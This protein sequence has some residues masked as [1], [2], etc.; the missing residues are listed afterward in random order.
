MARPR[1][2]FESKYKRY[3]VAVPFC[4]CHIW[5]GPITNHGYGRVTFGKHK[6]T[7]A[8]RASYQHFVGPLKDD[9]IIMHECDVPLCVNPLHLRKGTQAENIADKVAKKR[10]AAGEAHGMSKLSD[11]QVR[12]II[13]GTQDV[14][15]LAVLFHVSPCTVRQIRS[16]LYWRHIHEGMI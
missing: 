16:G 7:G 6:S 10:Q 2:S 1:E 14:T 11:D 8:H 13:S 4:G 5:T 9:E 12:E 15:A 3:A